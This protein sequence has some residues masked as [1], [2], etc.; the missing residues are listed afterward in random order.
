METRMKIR[1]KGWLVL[2]LV[3]A[4]ALALLTA[5]SPTQTQAPAQ[6]PNLEL[7][8]SLAGRPTDAQIKALQGGEVVAVGYTDVHDVGVAR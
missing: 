3:L 1:V 5:L 2:V 6:A 8:V 7:L 4:L